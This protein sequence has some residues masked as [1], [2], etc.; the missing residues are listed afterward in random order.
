[1]RKDFHDRPTV[2]ATSRRNPTGSR[3]LACCR[4]QRSR[5]R[6]DLASCGRHRRGVAADDR[7][8]AMPLATPDRFESMTAAHKTAA[9]RC[10]V[11]RPTLA[12]AVVLCG[13]GLLII[14]PARA[15]APPVGTLPAGPTVHLNLRAGEIF[16]LTLPR[17]VERGRVWRLARAYDAGVVRESVPFRTGL[18]KA[19]FGAGPANLAYSLRRD[20]D[21]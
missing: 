20:R 5:A 1:M 19:R 2:A 21:A 3:Y 18:T 16:T 12:A 8:T 9:Q 13:L 7:A 15:S 6:D 17:S 14:A 10:G 4:S 11:A